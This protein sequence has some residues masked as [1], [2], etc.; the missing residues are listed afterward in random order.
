MARQGVLLIPR[1]CYGQ[2]VIW[3]G[4]SCS[5]HLWLSFFFF[6]YNY[7]LDLFFGVMTICLYVCAL[8]RDCQ[9]FK[10]ASPMVVSYYVGAGQIQVFCK[11][12]CSY[13]W[14]VSPGCIFCSV[15]HLY[16][17]TV[18]QRKELSNKWSR[19][20]QG[21]AVRKTESF[22]TILMV[23]AKDDAYERLDHWPPRAFV[24]V[25]R[26]HTHHSIVP[27]EENVSCFQRL[28]FPQINPGLKLETA[29]TWPALCILS[30]IPSLFVTIM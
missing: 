1:A 17:Q 18:L 22:W 26:A 8:K 27:K 30:T 13:C 14:A 21:R 16:M 3:C 6:F 11:S 24:E 5:G 9:F 29:S 10:L 4:D 25:P 23:F 20:M 12:K 19:L 28:H 2:D 15:G 7:V